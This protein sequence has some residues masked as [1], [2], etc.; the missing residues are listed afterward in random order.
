MEEVRCHGV[1]A[2]VGEPAGDVLDVVVDSERLLDHDD[3]ATTAVVGN[4]L[5]HGHRPVGCL[6]FEGS[7][8]HGS[9]A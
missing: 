6:D 5:V 4:R 1:I 7:R 8:R 9:G 3:T 2:V